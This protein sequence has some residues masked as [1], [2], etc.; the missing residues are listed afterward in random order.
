MEKIHI[1]FK[2]Q[3][4]MSDQDFSWYLLMQALFH[5]CEVIERVIKGTAVKTSMTNL[6]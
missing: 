4:K 6:S 3:F 5:D 1:E 2:S